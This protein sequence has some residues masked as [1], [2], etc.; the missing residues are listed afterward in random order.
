MIAHKGHKIIP[1]EAL[2]LVKEKDLESGVSVSVN[3]MVKIYA[4]E[5]R[6]SKSAMCKPLL[7]TIKRC[8]SYIDLCLDTFKR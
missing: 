3:K 7:K 6:Y 2:L 5:G 8:E 4:I 1:T